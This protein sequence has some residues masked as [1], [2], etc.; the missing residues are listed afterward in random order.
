LR[1]FTVA[2]YVIYIYGRDVTRWCQYSRLVPFVNV[3]SK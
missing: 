2:I 3:V 1:K